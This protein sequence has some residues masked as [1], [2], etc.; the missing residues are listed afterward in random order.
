MNPDIL[1]I[2]LNSCDL[3]TL[4]EVAGK[5]L[6]LTTHEETS[7]AE[8]IENYGPEGK[9][10]LGSKD[11]KQDISSNETQNRHPVAVKNRLDFCMMS[12]SLT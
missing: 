1:T 12:T 10:R 5:L 11:L 9:S 6:S 2:I 7:V 4:P 8:I 3:P